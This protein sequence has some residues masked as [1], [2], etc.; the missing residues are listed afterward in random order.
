VD[1]TSACF[2]SVLDTV[3]NVADMIAFF[4]SVGTYGAAKTACATARKTGL[5][6]IKEGL[7]SALQKRAKD[8]AKK[9]YSE[10]SGGF[11]YVVD[12]LKKRY[13]DE[14]K[15]EMILE[16]GATML[17][18]A[19]LPDTVGDVA[20]E[21]AA[22]VD[23]TGIVSV[24]QS[25]TPPDACGDT[26]VYDKP[27]PPQGT[28]PAYTVLDVNRPLHECESDW[29]SVGFAKAWNTYCFR[30]SGTKSWA[31]APDCSYAWYYW[32]SNSQQLAR[33]T[34][35]EKSGQQCLTL[36]VSCPSCTDVKNTAS[37]RYWKAK[38][39]CYWWGDWMHKYCRETCGHCIPC[40]DKYR[41]C[42]Y[43]RGRGYCVGKWH[44]WM[45]I[46]CRSSCAHC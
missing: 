22:M 23:P 8:L 12:S 39:K 26:V 7:Q 2:L 19:N 21:I 17:L 31:M 14:D 3:L 32:G 29:P 35:T 5:K 10:A 13:K 45:G 4:A 28:G 38:G 41:S 25:F 33:D 6:S 37:C 43:W 46:N 36:E 24:V 27:L 11:K 44:S 15:V 16:Q 18:T 42:P 1:D 30:N 40:R 20:L 9:A 34:C